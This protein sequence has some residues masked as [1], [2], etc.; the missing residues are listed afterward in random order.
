MFKEFNIE[1]LENSKVQLE[2]LLNDSRKNR[3]ISK[4][5]K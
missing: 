3:G 2:E 4:F 1:N 5:R